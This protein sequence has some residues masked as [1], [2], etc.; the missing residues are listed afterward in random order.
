MKGPALGGGF[1]LG[2]GDGVSIGFKTLVAGSLEAQ[3][4]MSVELALFLRAYPLSANVPRG[5]FAQAEAGAVLH[6]GDDP[7][8]LPAETGRGVFGISAGWRFWLGNHWYIEPY[9]RGGYPYIIG[10]G[11]CAGLR[12]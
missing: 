8:A 7:L 12:L 6:A 10:G 2:M 11:V 9:I 3:S 5:F 4:L 1:M